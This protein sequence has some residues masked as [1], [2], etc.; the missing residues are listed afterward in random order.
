MC[1]SSVGTEFARARMPT[2]KP[3]PPKLIVPA[4]P[5]RRHVLSPLRATCPAPALSSPAPSAR[6][7]WLFCVPPSMAVLGAFPFCARAFMRYSLWCC[8]CDPPRV[9]LYP[10][11]SPCLVLIRI[12]FKAANCNYLYDLRL[13]FAPI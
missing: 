9:I 3:R 11:C 13:H 5:A 12:A 4:A 2:T 6:H 8:A 7:F 1:C 10:I